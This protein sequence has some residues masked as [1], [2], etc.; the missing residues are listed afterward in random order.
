MDKW[1]PGS[2]PQYGALG[3]LCSRPLGGINCCTRPSEGKT[4]PP[5]SVGF[6]RLLWL[7]QIC[8]RHICYGNAYLIDKRHFDSELIT[9]ES[10]KIPRCIQTV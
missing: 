6:Y 7:E 1:V 10:P 4:G 8:L 3:G 5:L 9:L 2:T